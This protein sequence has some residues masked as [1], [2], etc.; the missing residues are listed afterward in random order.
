ML[1]MQSALDAAGRQCKGGSNDVSVHTAGGER[2]GQLTV[3]HIIREHGVLLEDLHH[4]FLP[5]VF[6]LFLL[7]QAL[8]AALALA[9]FD[10][11]DFAPIVIK[12]GRWL[13]RLFVFFFSCDGK[14]NKRGE[15]FFLGVWA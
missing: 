2:G 14:R 4:A 1:D 5:V 8:L 9:F 15:V 6:F 10:L 7:E 13:V 3:L 12:K 11:V